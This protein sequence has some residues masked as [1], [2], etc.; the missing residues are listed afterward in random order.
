[1]DWEVDSM[2]EILARHR[3]RA[4]AGTGESGGAEALSGEGY[5]AIRNR[6]VPAKPPLASSSRASSIGAQPIYSDDEMSPDVRRWG[7]HGKLPGLGPCSRDSSAS[8]R[9]ESENGKV[10]ATRT[11]GRNDVE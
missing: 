3:A 4:K 7:S 9:S 6:G 2:D 5:G 11:R 8:Q 10:E 1:M